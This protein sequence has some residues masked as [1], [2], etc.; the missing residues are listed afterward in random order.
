MAVD[1]LKVIDFIT[2]RDDSLVLTISD[3]LEWDSKNEHLYFLQ[4]KINAYLMAIESGQ[5]KKSYP[6]SSDKDFVISVVLK[7]APNDTGT[8]F[9]SRIKDFLTNHGY[10]FEYQIFK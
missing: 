4:E 3:H 5:V 6:L 1:N 7:Y 10:G 2:E 9:L 8:S